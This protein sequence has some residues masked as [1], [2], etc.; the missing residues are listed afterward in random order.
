MIGL[1]GL[2]VVQPRT[3]RLWFI[4][5]FC[6]G[7]FP[8]QFRDFTPYFRKDRGLKP[9]SY[10]SKIGM[11]LAIPPK[12]AQCIH[13]T[14][15]HLLLVELEKESLHLRELYGKQLVLKVMRWTLNNWTWEHDANLIFLTFGFFRILERSIWNRVRIV[16]THC[17]FD[18][19]LRFRGF[20][21]LIQLV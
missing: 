16:G 18:I 21:C 12:T 5:G 4:D 11:M 9:A 14:S 10:E 17:I 6:L 15:P 3:W 7:L 13:S 2:I 1:N 19:L 20:G 8:L